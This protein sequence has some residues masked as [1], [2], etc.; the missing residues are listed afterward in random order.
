MAS[1]GVCTLPTDKTCL[2][3]PYF[4]VYRRV[5]FNPKSQSPIALE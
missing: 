5:A 1:V 3:P 2:Y 4:T